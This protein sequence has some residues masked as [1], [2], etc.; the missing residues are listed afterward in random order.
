MFRRLRSQRIHVFPQPAAVYA[1]E[2]LDDMV[3]VGGEALCGVCGE[4]YNDHPNHPDIDIPTLQITCD[5][6]PVKT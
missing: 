3:R 2:W 4:T 5:G 1:D 6:R